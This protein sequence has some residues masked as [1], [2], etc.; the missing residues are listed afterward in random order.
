MAVKNQTFDYMTDDEHKMVDDYLNKISLRIGECQDVYNRWEAEQEAYSGSQPIEE[1]CPNSRVNIMNCNI[2]GQIANLVDQN[3]AVNCRGTG[4][5]DHGFAHWGRIGLDWALRKNRIKKKI[6]RHE[7][8]RML[9]GVGI[10]KLIWNPDALNGFGLAEVKTPSISSVVVDGMIT[11]IDDI[12]YAEYI[13]EFMPMSKNWA[14]REFGDVANNINSGGNDLKAVFRKE[15]SQDDEDLFVYIQLWTKTDG[16]LRLIEFSDDGVLLSDSFK[17]FNGKKFKDIEHKPFYRYNK[18]PYWFTNLYY[19]EGEFWGFGDGKLLRP[20]Q[21]LINDLYDQ[22]RRLSR[23]ARLFFDPDSEVD[24]D[25]VDA[26]D[27][28]VPAK[29]PNRTIRSIDMGVVNP[30]LWQLLGNI[31]Q[32][33]QRIIRFSDLMLGHSSRTQTATEAN[34]Q[35][36]QGS[37]GIDHKKGQLETTLIDLAEYMMDMMIEKYDAGAAFRIDETKDDFEWID[38]RKLDSVPVMTPATDGYVKEYMSSNPDQPPPK[39]Q[40]LKD[41]TG[42]DMTKRVD[43][44]IEITFGSGMP[45]NKA[46]LWQMAERLGA[47]VI[48][49][50]PLVHYKEMRSFCKDFLGMPLDD[51]YDMP[52]PALPQGIPGQRP[53][54]ADMPMQGPETPNMSPGGYPMP[55]PGSEQPISPASLMGG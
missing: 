14:I 43:F 54:Q 16:M 29:D 27:N 6:D 28:A 2:E 10:F 44:D 7:R 30:A 8:R 52:Q 39:F 35:Q 42:F 24:L 38:F 21:D 47:I 55:Q 12:E 46:F 1:D 15:R 37:S 4:P 11:D 18:Y 26:S 13:A 36:Q 23:P 9:F 19:E 32:E 49:Q 34:I 51:T 31:H 5:S 33:I 41:D 40:V 53:G 45:K 22:I 20:L 48:E 3:L 25:E 17:E 50:Q